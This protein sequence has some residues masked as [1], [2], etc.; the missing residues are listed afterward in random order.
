S[1]PPGE[2]E[3]SFTFDLGAVAEN[4]TYKGI[5]GKPGV[6]AKWPG[7][8]ATWQQVVKQK[9]TIVQADQPMVEVI[10][11]PQ[12]D[13]FK[14][15]SIGVKSALARPSSRGID[16]IINWQ[17]VGGAE[18]PVCY[19]VTGIAG[20][21]KIELGGMAIRGNGGPNMSFINVKSLPADAA[22]LDI[23]FTPD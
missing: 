20:A 5:D 9:V 21:Q 12:R 6:P 7:P 8:I 13:P 14:T 10:T 4:S 18:P 19:R 3:L 16:I 11:D 22:S 2:Q 23:L 1:L 15:F 17:I